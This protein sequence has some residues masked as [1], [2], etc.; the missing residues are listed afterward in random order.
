MSSSIES[1]E[2]K[3]NIKL[4]KSLESSSPQFMVLLEKLSS[5]LDVSGRTKTSQ[6][7]LDIAKEKTQT[8]RRKF[9]ETSIRVEVLKE[10]VLSKLQNKDKRIY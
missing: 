8:A 6:T 9:L 4:S 7:Q 2:K 5:V 1:L 10:L 3:L